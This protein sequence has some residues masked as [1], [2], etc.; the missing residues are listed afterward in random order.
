[1]NTPEHNSTALFQHFLEEIDSKSKQLGAYYIRDEL[2]QSKGIKVPISEFIAHS[3]LFQDS[4]AWADI[5]SRAAYHKRLQI[6]SQPFQDPELDE[7]NRKY[8]DNR[9][10]LNIRVKAGEDLLPAE[11]HL[12]CAQF[13]YFNYKIY[14]GLISATPILTERRF[15]SLMESQEGKTAEL[16]ATVLEICALLNSGGGVILFDTFRSYLEVWPKGEIIEEA[17]SKAATALIAEEIRSIRPEVCMNEHI[18]VSFVPLARNPIT[19][20]LAASGRSYI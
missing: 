18:F 2:P 14:D 10:A 3:P 19:D 9:N 15:L 20:G 8:K 16:A 11:D 5:F 6:E 17:S 13:F 7:E 4:Y 12:C 1:V